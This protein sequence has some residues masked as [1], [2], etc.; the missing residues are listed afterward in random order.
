MIRENDALVHLD[1]GSATSVIP[2][3]N[4][5]QLPRRT[6]FHQV[7]LWRGGNRL[8]TIVQCNSD[9]DTIC[10]FGKQVSKPAATR[11]LLDSLQAADRQGVFQLDK[12]LA[13]GFPAFSLSK[14]HFG[15]GT[16]KLSQPPSGSTTDER[17]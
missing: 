2:D 10:I 7:F 12:Y 8:S 3:A 16:S 9:A 14:R 13:V 1:K 5:L 4:V 15:F 17:F 11:L 6:V